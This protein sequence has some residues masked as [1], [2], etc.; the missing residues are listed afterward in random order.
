M[1]PWRYPGPQCQYRLLDELDRGT[2]C[3]SCSRPPCFTGNLS[4][5]PDFHSPGFIQA[6]LGNPAVIT[7]ADKAEFAIVKKMPVM[8][9]R[10]RAYRTINNY[11]SDRTLYFGSPSTYQLFALES[12]T[13]LATTEWKYRKKTQT[14]GSTLPPEFSHKLKQQQIFYRWVRKAYKLKYGD[15]ADVPSLIHKGMSKELEKRIQE[16]RGSIRVKKIHDEGFHAGGF[17]PRPIKFNHHYLFGTLSDHATGMAVDIDDKKNPQLT[18]EEWNFIEQLVGKDIKRS[19]RWETEEDAEGLWD[20]ISEM[21]N[22]FVKRVA[23]EVNRIEK[24][25]AEKAKADKEKAAKQMLDKS[26]PTHAEKSTKV[27]P[28]L[29]EILGPHLKNLSPWVNSGFFHLPLDLVLELHAHGF[30]W[31]ATFSTNVDLHHFQIDE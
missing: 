17:N 29:H 4:L 30:T 13:E 19:G 9:R 5:I 24:E 28:P 31:G 10:R 18:L 22:L 20:D 11:V 14:L 1:A 6:A 3:R 26:E 7:D 12:D 21:S 27:V 23:A 16:V 8:D 2:S 15:D 25:R